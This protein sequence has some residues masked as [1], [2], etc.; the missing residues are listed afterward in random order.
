[1]Y[2]SF[3]LCFLSLFVLLSLE[4]KVL[5]KLKCVNWKLIM[6]SKMQNQKAYKYQ[7]LKDDS[8]VIWESFQNTL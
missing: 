1:M 5:L 6:C 7:N 3:L 8:N 4:T 2:V